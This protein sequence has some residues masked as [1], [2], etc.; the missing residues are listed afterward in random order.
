MGDIRD[1]TAFVLGA[2]RKSGKGGGKSIDFGGGK[3]SFERMTRGDEERLR[4][5]LDWLN[6]NARLIHRVKFSEVEEELCK[7]DVA[8]AMKVLKDVELK[9]HEL[10]DP[11]AYVLSNASR[12]ARTGDS[13]R[14]D[15]RYSRRPRSSDEQSEWM[16]AVSR[17]VG[18]LN[19][20]YTLVD[21]VSYQDVKEPLRKCG[22][23]GAIKIL[24]DL[25]AANGKMQVKDPTQYVMTACR[26]AV[27]ERTLSRRRN[28]SDSRSRS[29]SR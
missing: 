7:L 29:R 16:K 8:T 3:R 27:A 15:E 9:A 20:F 12:R 10:R 21:K 23:L 2:V 25:V 6:D 19:N 17:Q 14:S 1:P 13:G 4:K 24:Q 26:N 5:H 28:R 18:Q 22:F 11:T